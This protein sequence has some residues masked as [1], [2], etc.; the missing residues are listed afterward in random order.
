MHI[1]EVLR[2]SK[3]QRI[4]DLRHNLLST[5]GIGSDISA[6]EWENI[7]RQLLHLGYLVQDFSRFGVLRLSQTARPVLKGETEV[8]LG[9]PRN[10]VETVEKGKKRIGGRKDYDQALFDTLRALR[11][12]LADAAGVPPF[13]VFSDATLAE[14]ARHLPADRTQFLRISGVGDHKLRQYGKAFLEAIAGYGKN[15]GAAAIKLT[16]ADLR[17][18]L[19]DTQMET[20]RLYRE[21]LDLQGICAR[22]GLKGSTI[23]AHLEELLDKGA[24]LDLIRL[25]DEAKVPLI[26]ER[27]G[28]VG[29]ESLSLL[30]EGLPDDISYEDIRLVRGGWNRG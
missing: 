19:S 17:L 21:G 15:S 4:M 16:N 10:T 27:L 13:V 20:L 29:P 25:V 5:Y 9:R 28:K 7:L 26:Q 2:G 1:I 22:R 3:S 6:A 24:E 30:K 11:K 12:Q 8:I 23:S 14:M 18:V